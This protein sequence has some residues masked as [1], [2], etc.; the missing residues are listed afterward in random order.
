MNDATPPRHVSNEAAPR[1]TLRE[2]ARYQ[3]T[4]SLSGDSWQAVANRASDHAFDKGY[5]AGYAAGRK[6]ER[7]LNDPFPVEDRET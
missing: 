4:V 5:E 6:A 1:A 3:V 7:D 2:Q